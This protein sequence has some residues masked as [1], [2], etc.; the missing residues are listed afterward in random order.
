MCGPCSEY[1]FSVENLCKDLYLR[2]Q[3]DNEGYVLLSEIAQFN[4]VKHITT[5]IRLVSG[6]TSSLMSPLRPP[7]ID[8]PPLHMPYV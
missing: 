5:D 2:R 3:M 1:Y 8:S 6:P 7:P 4:R